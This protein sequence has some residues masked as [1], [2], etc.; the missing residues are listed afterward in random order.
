LSAF[1][2]IRAIRDGGGIV[3]LDSGMG[4]ELE[5]RGVPMDDHAWCGLANLRQPEVVRDIHKDNIRAGADVIIA[6][7]F[8]SG[9]GPMQRAGVGDQF[10]LGIRNAIQAAREAVHRAAQ[11]PVAIAGSVGATAWGKP[12]VDT[13]SDRPEAEQLRDGYARLAQLLVDGGVDVIA[14]EMVVGDEPGEPAIDAALSSGLPVWLGLS[15]QV[16][17]HHAERTPSLPEVETEGRALAER[18]VSPELDA[19]NVMHTDIRDA[20]DALRMLRPL[21]SGPLGV[22][23]HH[24]RWSRPNWTFLNVPTAQLTALVEA[25][26]DLGVTMIGGCCGLRPH[27][28]AAL[29]AAAD[30]RTAR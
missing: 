16:V 2:H 26:F 14:L 23:P 10:E 18:I 24:G 27:H 28:V 29:R 22:Y 5:A 6:N 7:T 19:V 8:M 9:L 4:T 21:W 13:D 25:W 30:A 17:A 20:A 3:V 15:M 1:D 12:P 11:K